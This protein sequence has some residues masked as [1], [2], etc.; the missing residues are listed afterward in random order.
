MLSIFL[1][2]FLF[3]FFVVVVLFLFLFFFLFFLQIKMSSN[4]IIFGIC[5][6]C[7]IFNLKRLQNI[8]NMS[9]VM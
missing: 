8:Q 9:F 6:A 5:Y 1:F 2:L 4:N 3:L 7:I